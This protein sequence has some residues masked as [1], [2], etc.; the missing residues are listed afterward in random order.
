MAVQEHS[1]KGIRH[2][3]YGESAEYERITMAPTKE[4]IAS[5]TAC[6]RA[7]YDRADQEEITPSGLELFDL[8]INMN[9]F[10]SMRLQLCPDCIKDLRS[11]VFPF[12]A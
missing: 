8:V 7:N 2:E 6:G 12:S 10:Q 9:G 4:T 1:T 5:C 3:F 11:K